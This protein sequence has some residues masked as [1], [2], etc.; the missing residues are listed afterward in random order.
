MIR[1]TLSLAYTRTPDDALLYLSSQYGAGASISSE[2]YS[3]SKAT[4]DMCNE[5]LAFMRS[6]GFM[7]ASYATQL[8]LVLKTQCSDGQVQR[9]TR[10]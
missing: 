4:F 6:G 7:V 10:R 3:P 8:V 9:K 2:S 5:I 1:L